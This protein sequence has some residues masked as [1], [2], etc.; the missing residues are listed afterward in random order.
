MPY[1]INK[2]DGTA[3]LTLNDGDLDTSTSLGLLGRNYVGYGE[4]QNENFVFLL[5]HFAGNNP[6][7]RPIKGQAWY[8]TSKLLFNV[9]N[10][11]TWVPVGTAFESEA[12][13]VDG[14]IGSFWLK[15]SSKQL[16]MLVA[17]DEW[18]LVGPQRSPGFG[19]TEA[20]SSVLKDTEGVSHAVILV[21]V[22]G[23]VEAI[24]VSESFEISVT[25][26]VVGFL[27]LTKGINMSDGSMFTGTLNGNA[28]TSTK[29]KNTRLI[30]GVPFD[31]TADITINASTLNFLKNGQYIIGTD[32]N[33]SQNVTWSVDGTPLNVVGKVVVRDENGNFAGNEITAN[34]FIGTLFGNVN[35][36]TGTSFFN[37]IICPTIE[38][39]IFNGSAQSATKLNPGCTIN[40]VYFDGSA[41]V[42][43]SANAET[44]TG[45]FINPTVIN[46]SLRT[47]GI[48]ENLSTDNTGINIDNKLS[49]K[50]VGN[51]PTISAESSVNLL[52]GTT[53]PDVSFVPSN[54]AQLE[55]GDANPAILSNNDVNIGGPL[56]K[57]NKI[58]AN[59]LV[60]IAESS[61]K[62]T[63]TRTINGVP[64]NGTQ[65]IVIEDSTK[66]SKTG[67][68]I[69]GNLQ[70]NGKITLPNMP[71]N[72][73]DAVNKSYVDTLVANKPLFF[74][75]DTRG[76]NVTG[77]GAGSVVAIL[78]TLAPPAT[79]VPG[80]LCRVASTVQNITTSYSAPTAS[81]IAFT[82][83]TRVSV[84]TTVND[85]IRR[86]TLVY[87]VNNLRTSWEYVSG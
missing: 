38:G 63:Y 82:Y 56:K 45:T 72:G 40:G 31:G 4:V 53:G 75:L 3:L 58:Y 48:Q 68:T 35:A 15:Q 8:D 84:S 39:Q 12:A 27:I 61:N 16:Y 80:T 19:T 87:K 44:L 46:S 47:V 81:F 32:F 54:I 83:V 21:Y 55:G 1:I 71:V 65:N 24:A 25:T 66:L 10:G 57:F 69:T 51:I 20:H 85:P 36:E 74:S 23:I 33:G 67:G 49:I 9:Y 77:A 70:V 42:T 60:G 5:E 79:I 76:L 59:L 28:L 37:K 26:P 18:I 29:L 86:N 14:S 34:K 78:N 30:N 73:S 11:N 22:N 2:S 7:A 41:N 52:V 6:P 50:V 62:L 17:D 13:P 64:F 43:V